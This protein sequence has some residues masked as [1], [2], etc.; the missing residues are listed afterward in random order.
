MNFDITDNKYKNMQQSETDATAKIYNKLVRDK[1]PEIIMKS[2]KSCIVEKVND[3]EKYI[4][5]KEKLQ[6]EVNEFLE[7][8]N[9]QELGDIMEVLFGLAKSLGYSEKDLMK[10]RDEKRE[11]RGGFEEGVVLLKVSNPSKDI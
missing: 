4:L 8:D 7:A 6:E 9:L 5:L 11:E 3:K 1:I 10:K 2:G